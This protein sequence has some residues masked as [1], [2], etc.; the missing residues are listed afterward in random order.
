MGPSGKTAEMQPFCHGVPSASLLQ[1]HAFS[2]RWQSR[3]TFC[4]GNQRRGLRQ[5][6]Q[7]G[8]AFPSM[9]TRWLPN[10]ESLSSGDRV[11]G[12]PVERRRARPSPL[13]WPAFPGPGVDGP[14]PDM[15]LG[16]P[17]ELCPPTQVSNPPLLSP[18]SESSRG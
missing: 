17:P 8:G 5:N 14:D 10:T 9:S 2:Q 12:P 1:Y 7:E 15:S 6:G 16:R 4:A 18:P 11:G 3:N 13:L